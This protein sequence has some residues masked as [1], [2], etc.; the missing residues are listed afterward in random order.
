VKLPAGHF[1][2][3][4]DN[5]IEYGMM[6]AIGEGFQTLY[7]KVIRFDLAEVARVWNH[8]SVIR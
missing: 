1:L 4:Y 6:Q 2:K 8:D 7:D 5:R 3:M